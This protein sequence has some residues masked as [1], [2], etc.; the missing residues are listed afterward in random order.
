MRRMIRWA[1]NGLAAGSLLAALAAIALGLLS[2]RQSAE[3]H[4]YPGAAEVMG[5]ACDGVLML[6]VYR[7]DEPT[8]TPPDDAPRVLGLPY[9][10]GL[11]TTPA[12]EVAPNWAAGTKWSLAGGGFIAETFDRPGPGS[13]PYPPNRPCP[14]FWVAPGWHVGVPWWFAGAAFGLLPG[15][16]A[17][18]W[19]RRRRLGGGPAFEVV[20]KG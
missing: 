12:F 4:V 2:H 7:C 17:L 6:R 13:L 16:R 19:Y 9:D 20:T 18:G 10:Y 5:L 1:W 14:A 8:W 11:G 15:W 3:L